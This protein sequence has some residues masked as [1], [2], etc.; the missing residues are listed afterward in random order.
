MQ[1]VTNDELSA[2]VLF[3]RRDDPDLRAIA[4]AITRELGEGEEPEVPSGAI[5]LPVTDGAPRLETADVA[6]ALDAASAERARRAGVPRV[7][8][9]AP[10]FA[11]DG[12]G[13]IDADLVLVPHEALVEQAVARG[14]P[15]ARV[16]GVGPVAPEGFAP[17]DDRAALRARLGPPPELPWI[18]VRAAAIEDDP[19]A[20]L[21][22]LSLVRREAVWLFDVA[23]DVELAHHL[24]RR[25]PGYGIDAFMFA[26]GPDAR[27]AYQAAD[28]VLGRLDGIEIV[29][30]AAVGAAL[31]VLPPRG[32]QLRLADALDG[33]GTAHVADAAATLAVTLDRLLE[34]DALAKAR[35]ASSA[36]EARGG[37][38]RVAR[39]VRQLVR[40]ELPAPGASG[41]P[42]G[43]E[44]IGTRDEKGAR[45]PEAPLP[46][47]DELDREVDEE[48]AAL[49]RKLGL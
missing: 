47:K 17:A 6:I 9:L 31:A 26:D 5:A 23:S 24:R 2:V 33:S 40:G 14:V 27:S 42:V 28:A 3:E 11:L 21:V 38:E 8:V 19:A 45:E 15:A 22:Q 49:R 37:A 29:R 39:I 35:A 46:R 32:D 7:V 44:R 43:L 12:E 36:L 18:V 20:A 30:A 41:L 48:L 25:V 13:P 16:H 10:R 1:G 4:A 34:P